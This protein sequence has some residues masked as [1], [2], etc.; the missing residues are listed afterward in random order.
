LLPYTTLFRSPR[1]PEGKALPA[2]EN[3]FDHVAGLRRF[4]AGKSLFLGSSR[5]AIAEV[6]SDQRLIDLHAVFH[7]GDLELFP[8]EP[9]AQRFQ[10][11]SRLQVSPV[12]GLPV[13]ASP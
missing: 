3:H 10:R 12:G 8:L 13:T 9:A 7:E 1:L 5:I 11:L 6:Q 2:L 4:N